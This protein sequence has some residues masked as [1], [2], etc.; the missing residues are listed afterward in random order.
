[1]EE[2]SFFFSQTKTFSFELGRR[3]LEKKVGQPASQWTSQ[4]ANQP[5]SQPTDQ[6]V[7]VQKEKDRFKSSIGL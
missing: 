7:G 6:A 1:M 4:P 2:K 5:A 3:P